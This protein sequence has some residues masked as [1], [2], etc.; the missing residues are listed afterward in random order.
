MRL[1]S[2]AGSLHK[3]ENT[4]STVALLDR[5]LGRDAR[6]FELSGATTKRCNKR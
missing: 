5:I 4:P 6:R 1:V 2:W 3:Y